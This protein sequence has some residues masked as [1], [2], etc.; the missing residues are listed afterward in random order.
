[1]PTICS[2]RHRA[3]VPDRERH[4]FLGT[5]ICKCSEHESTGR[6]AAR[7]DVFECDVLRDLSLEHPLH[8][9]PAMRFPDLM[10]K[11]L[12]NVHG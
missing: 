5:L 9:T 10:R 7:S 2:V 8:L 1:M 6:S 12:N 4:I 3:T 11:V